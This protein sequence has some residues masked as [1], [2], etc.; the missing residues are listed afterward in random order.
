MHTLFI[1]PLLFY[2]RAE[3]IRATKPA[4]MKYPFLLFL[5]CPL[6]SFSQ[7]KK[8][9]LII[10]S[11]NDTT[12]LYDNIVAF[13][14]AE[15]YKVDPPGKYRNN[16]YTKSKTLGRYISTTVYYSFRIVEHTINIRGF[17]TYERM[18]EKAMY[19]Y[20]FEPAW[21]EMDRLAKLL[22]TV[23]YAREK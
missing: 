16:I 10:V 7:E 6:F 14:Q 9:N 5:L 20:G 22:G 1:Y 4:T 11:P 17:Y 21:N 3:Y 12:N 18:Q 23:T 19:N 2:W 13:L 15:G 8:A